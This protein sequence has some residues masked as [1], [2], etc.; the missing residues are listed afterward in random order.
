MADLKY[1][2][3]YLDTLPT[4]KE[5]QFDEVG[6]LVV[7]LME[8]ASTGQTSVQLQGER[9]VYTM[10]KAQIDRDAETYA[11]KTAASRENGKKGGRPRKSE[12]GFSET[13]NNP[14]NPVGF[15][16]TQKSQ[17]KEKEKEKDN[18]KE[19][20]RV[21]ALPLPLRDPVEKYCSERIPG[22]TETNA[23]DMRNFI[24]KGIPPNLIRHAVD[25][26][27]ASGKPSWGYCHQILTRYVT[28]GICSIEEV[29]PK[30]RIAAND[31]RWWN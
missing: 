17:E 24:E 18:E 25:E 22:F 7:A 14:E 27:C 1:V 13:Q 20:E 3:L 12:T 5:M 21:C 31:I 6:R 28:D 8:Y 10:L 11:R 26:A 23:Q 16:E 15:S 9:Y 30:Q 2:M 19:K 29:T 4:F